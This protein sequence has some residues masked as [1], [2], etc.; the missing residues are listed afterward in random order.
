MKKLLLLLL[1]I[2]FTGIVNA[3]NDSIKIENVYKDTTVMVTLENG[4]GIK[5]DIY[6]SVSGKDFYLIRNTISFKDIT[7][8]DIKKKV[9]GSITFEIKMSA[10]EV[11][12]LKLKNGTSL[13]FIDAPGKVEFKQDGFTFRY[14]IKAQNSYGNFITS[15]VI[16]TKLSNKSLEV[17]IY[18]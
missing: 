18:H 5:R 3:Q 10:I 2:L 4:V 1:L 7:E 12:Y 9:I 6:F 13:D 11:K 14:Y 17:S 8:E 15:Q 16:G